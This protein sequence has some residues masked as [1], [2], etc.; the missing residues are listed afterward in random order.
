MPS[1]IT[2]SVIMLSFTMLSV[3][4]LNVMAPQ[5]LKDFP[6]SVSSIQSKPGGGG[7]KLQSLI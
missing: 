7:S 6:S 3:I 2:L 1:V 4:M 5:Y